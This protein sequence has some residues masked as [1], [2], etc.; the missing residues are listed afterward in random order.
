MIDTFRKWTFL[1]WL[2]LI[3]VFFIIIHASVK[4]IKS[5][6]AKGDLEAYFHASNQIVNQ[7]DIYLTPS[8]DVSQ[9]GVFYLYLPLL[10]ILLIPL[11]FLPIEANIIL[12]TFVNTLL[13]FY[14]VK[15]FYEMMSGKSFFGLQTKSRWILSFFPILLTSPFILHH[16]AYGQAN[17]LVMAL[18]I[19][20]LSLLSKRRQL[21]GGFIIGLAMVIKIIGAPIVVWL[22]VKRFYRTV[23]GVVI[24]VVFGAIL[25]PGLITGF[26]QNFSYIDFWLTKIVFAGD[27]GTEKVALV[28]NFSLQAQL[29]RFFT[30]I[31]A[32]S[33]QNKFYSLTIYAL[34]PQ[35]IHAV[36]LFLQ[37]LVLLTIFFYSIKYKKSEELISKWGGIALTFALIPLFATTT[38]KHYFVMLLPSYTYA[39][40]VWHCRKLKDK[41]FR[42]LLAASFVVILITNDG[43][44]GDLLSNIFTAL[45][46]NLW[47]TILLML[48]I[49]RIAKC[50]SDN[51][52]N[53][54]SV[55]KI[56]DEKLK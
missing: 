54:I 5:P 39:V 22:V 32:F 21:S 17:I 41:W 15:T 9:G 3:I 14:V 27:L 45:G 29:Y 46:F 52:E 42:G 10:A 51:D 18:M 24:G 53:N 36:G 33:Y 13:I 43:I 1:R 20:G 4:M 37:L 25:L 55:D 48:C 49:F 19:F 34:S 2:I 23:W 12:W 31:P 11:T 26:K 7:Q 38:Q 30:E 16:L 50:F 6:L 47:G 28:F 8:R 40:Y 35:I 56:N 44:V